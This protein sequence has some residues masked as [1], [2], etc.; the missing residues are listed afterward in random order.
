VCFTFR[1]GL[2]VY[3]TYG[4]VMTH[5]KSTG[6]QGKTELNIGYRFGKTIFTDVGFNVGYQFFK[7]SSV[8]NYAGSN[9]YPDNDGKRTVNLDF[10]GLYY[11][12][13]LKI[14]K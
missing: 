12:I 5:Y 2:K 4:E 11:G 3:N 10:S 1:S 8:K 13:Y 6:F 14:G 9:I 7:T